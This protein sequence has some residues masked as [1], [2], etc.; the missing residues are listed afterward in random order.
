MAAYRHRALGHHA[1]DVADEIADGAYLIGIVIADFHLDEPILDREHQFD[2]VEPV[3]SE[4][5]AEVR[6]VRD[7][8]NVDSELLGNEGADLAGVKA[9][10]RRRCGLTRS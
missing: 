2:P 3:G 1:L 6:L 4:I 5:V 8:G 9:V 7:A 10:V